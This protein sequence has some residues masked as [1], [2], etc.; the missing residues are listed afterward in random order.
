MK[1]IN[2]SDIGGVDA[3]QNTRPVQMNISQKPQLNQMAQEFTPHSV[4]KKQQQQQLL[5]QQQQQLAAAQGFVAQQQQQQQQQQAGGFP[6][7]QQAAL[8]AA[9][10]NPATLQAM[11]QNQNPHFLHHIQQQQLQQLQQLHQQNLRLAAAFNQNQM[12]IYNATSALL[13]QIPPGQENEQ[14]TRGQ[15]VADQ[16]NNDFEHFPTREDTCPSPPLTNPGQCQ[17]KKAKAK[18]KDHNKVSQLQILFV[19]QQ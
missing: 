14:P 4:A 1:Y 2:V 11:L 16:T 17:A 12:G 19:K 10:M 7:N 15:T 8:Q 3:V 13:Q 18:G 6:V 9:M 5:Q